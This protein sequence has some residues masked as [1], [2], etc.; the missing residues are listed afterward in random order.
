MLMK[1]AEVM[2]LAVGVGPTLDYADATAF[3][4]EFEPIVDAV[5]K[6]TSTPLRVDSTGQATSIRGSSQ[7]RQGSHLRN[8]P[9]Y[10]WTEARILNH[11]RHHAAVI[12]DRG[13]CAPAVSSV[14]ISHAQEFPASCLFEMRQANAICARQNGRT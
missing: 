1:A 8:L 9:G 5:R 2:L 12:G 7:G 11:H 6:R 13:C 4:S 14:S 3:L 10:L